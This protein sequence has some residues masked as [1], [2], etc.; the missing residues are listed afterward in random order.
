MA[1]VRKVENKQVAGH[2]VSGVVTDKNGDPLVGVT[3]VIK[4]LTGE[5]RRY[6]WEIFFGG[7][8]GCATL[9]LLLSG[10]DSREVSN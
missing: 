5:R 9:F 1:I 8:P 6:R 2:T 7:N 3:I 4:G 10:M